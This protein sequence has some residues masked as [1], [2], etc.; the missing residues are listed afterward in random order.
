MPPR[1]MLSAT[2]QRVEEA[3]ADRRDVEGDAIVDA[4]H[5]PGPCVAL[6]GK[7]WSGV[8]VARTIRPIS[9]GVDARPPPAPLRAASVAERRGG[10]AVAGDVAEADAG[11]LDDPFVGGVDGLG[12]LGIGHAPR[13]AAPSRCR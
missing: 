8:A 12:Q 4:E 1:I 5:R 7:V 2:V 9:L 13:A 3:R 6:A 10:L 11:A